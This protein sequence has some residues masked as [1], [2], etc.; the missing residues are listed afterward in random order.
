MVFIAACG[1]GDDLDDRLDVA[2]PTVRF[3]HASPLFSGRVTFGNNQDVM[4][5]TVPDFAI[6]GIK[7]LKQ[8]EGTLAVTEVAPG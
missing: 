1:G 5:V 6:G 3:V 8:V 2:D 4:L 7:L